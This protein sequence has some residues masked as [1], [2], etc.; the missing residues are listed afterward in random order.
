M[1]E[2]LYM[3][4]KRG[5]PLD[6]SQ[7]PKGDKTFHIQCL[8]YAGFES[9]IFKSIYGRVD[10]S[11]QDCILDQLLHNVNE[12]LSIAGMVSSYLPS[13]IENA[14]FREKLLIPE[15][16]VESSQRYMQIF[17]RNNPLKATQPLP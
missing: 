15:T 1:K 3:I 11:S 16:V 8:E 6:V 2:F 7:Y 4:P 12:A 10:K 13:L 14:Q 17:L 5:L 9:D